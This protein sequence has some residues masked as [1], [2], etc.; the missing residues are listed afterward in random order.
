MLGRRLITADN[1]LESWLRRERNPNPFLKNS[2]FLGGEREKRQRPSKNVCHCAASRKRGGGQSGARGSRRRRRRNTTLNK[3][4]GI[5]VNAEVG[6]V[7][8][9]KLLPG[10]LCDRTKSRGSLPRS[11]RSTG[12]LCECCTWEERGTGVPRVGGCSLG[13]SGIVSCGEELRSGATLMPNGKCI[14]IFAVTF[15]LVFGGRAGVSVGAK[16]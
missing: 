12:S 5:F 9:A 1:Y 6:H 13:I 10:P 15:S 14:V 11:V 3:C 4:G 8:R 2:F 7:A 16:S